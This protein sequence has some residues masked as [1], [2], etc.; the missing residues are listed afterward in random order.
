MIADE[1]SA[2]GIV[3]FGYF[4]GQPFRLNLSMLPAYPVLLAQIAEALD[5]LR[6]PTMIDRL[7]TDALSVSLGVLLSV[8]CSVPLVYSRGT[9][10]SGV[11]DLVGAYDVGHPTLLVVHEWWGGASQRAFI[12]KAERVGLE[13]K[14][15]LAL[16]DFTSTGEVA[17]LFTFDALLET[18]QA[19]GRLPAGQVAAVRAWLK[20]NAP[21]M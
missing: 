4:D 5:A 17:S 3:Q 10:E 13:V 14:V 2:A 12:E 11:R 19:S 16:I 18:L 21:G 20:R 15:V 7:L 9:D 8:R 1:L 6:P